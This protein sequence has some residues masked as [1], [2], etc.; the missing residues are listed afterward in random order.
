MPDSVSMFNTA[1]IC[2]GGNTRAANSPNCADLAYSAAAAAA[3]LNEGRH[4]D[5]SSWLW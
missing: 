4:S 1:C 2:S 3:V 5:P